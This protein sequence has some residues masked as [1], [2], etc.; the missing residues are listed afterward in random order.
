MK[1]VF[2]FF[3]LIFIAF[4]LQN[5]SSDTSTDNE[6]EL[7]PAV[8]YEALNVS[9]GNE[10]RQ[11]LDLYLPAN[12]S[13]NTK[14][15]I[16]V[17]GDG[18][19]SGDKSDMNAIKDLIRIDFPNHAIV[20]INYRYANEENKPYPMQTDDITSVI[21]HLKSN[22][23]NYTISDNF[24]FI[25]ASAGAHLSLL[26]S[27]A[28]DTDNN[29]DMVCSIV[30][31]T[32]LT[33]PEYL[34][35]NNEDLQELLDMFGEF[36]ETSYL[37]EAS[38]LHRVTADAPPSILFYGGKDPLIPTSQGIDLKNKL[39]NLNVVH[40]FT[41]YENEAHGWEGLALIDTWLKLKAF[42]QTHLN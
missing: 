37:E 13:L 27:Y 3:C 15:V 10:N 5:C 22:S 23:E 17:H 7:N 38:P 21:N 31:P 35:N 30:G 18:W 4:C 14:T 39:A 20:N 16:L 34:N 26:W 29:I 28:L 33:D 6:D 25:G 24:G 12:R 1:L 11:K 36:P 41:L 2:K 32:N 42:M 9:Y 40:E 19:I 8:Y